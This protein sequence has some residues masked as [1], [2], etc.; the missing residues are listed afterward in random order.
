VGTCSLF[1]HRDE[2]LRAEVDDLGDTALGDKEVRV[3]D[4]ELNRF[5]HVLNLLVAFSVAVE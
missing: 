3:V 2:V 4:V 1:D 5:E